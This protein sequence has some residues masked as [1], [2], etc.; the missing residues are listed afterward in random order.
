MAAD[1]IKF[2]KF[3]ER[4]CVPSVYRF[5]NEEEREMKY[6]VLGTAVALAFPL[7][8]GATAANAQDVQF[9]VGDRDH[10]HWR[11]RDRD[12]WRGPYASERGCRMVVTKRINSA[13]DRVTVRKRICG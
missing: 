2:R 13:G 5:R 1:V 4:L 7:I 8:A 11:D 3:R 12:H 6:L 10:G 9:S